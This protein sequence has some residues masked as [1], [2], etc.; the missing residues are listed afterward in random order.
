MGVGNVTRNTT[1]WFP[2]TPGGCPIFW[3]PR[4]YR[5]R[6]SN[7][8]VPAGTF[9]STT[10]AVEP[11]PADDDEPA[12]PSSV[13]TCTVVPRIA[14]WNGIG[15]WRWQGRGRGRG[16]LLDEPRKSHSVHYHHHCQITIIKN[17]NMDNNVS[18]IQRR[19][20]PLEHPLEHLPLR[21]RHCPGA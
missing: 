18:H 1:C 9:S 20:A 19:D 16:W 8:C 3:I 17:M 14:W 21:S 10:P 5:I 4:P 6:F 7:G 11:A 2:R 12:G 13:G 15:S